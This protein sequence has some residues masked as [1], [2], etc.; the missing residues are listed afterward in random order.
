[1]FDAGAISNTRP[2]QT[3]VRTHQVLAVTSV[4]AAVA[5][6]WVLQ[7]MHQASFWAADTLKLLQLL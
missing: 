4:A 6:M 1:V 2:P 3:L 7:A 5:A